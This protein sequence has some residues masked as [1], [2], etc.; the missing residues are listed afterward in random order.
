M[1]LLF[2][3][4]MQGVLKSKSK[5]NMNERLASILEAGIDKQ[6][7]KIE[8]GFTFLATVGLTVPFIGLF[9]TVWE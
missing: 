5:S 4:S 1:A 2:K 7:S 9:G 6:I 3:E 8:K